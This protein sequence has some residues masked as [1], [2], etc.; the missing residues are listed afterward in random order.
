MVAQRC[1]CEEFALRSSSHSVVVQ[2]NKLNTMFD[3]LN[4]VRDKNTSK[5]CF[6]KTLYIY[7]E[8]EK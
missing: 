3:I 4:F 6:K 8:R 7:G 2:N 5:S 1:F